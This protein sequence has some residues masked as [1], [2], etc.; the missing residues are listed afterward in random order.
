MPFCA[1]C[2][3][4]VEGRFCAKCGGAVAGDAGATGSRP[5]AAGGMTDNVASALCYV[6]TFIT[7]IVFLVL[8]PYNKNKTVRFHAFQ[9]IFMGAGILVF[10]IACSLIFGILHLGLFGALLFPLIGL[11]F[12]ILWIYM[13]ISAYQGKKVVLPLIGPLAEQQ[14]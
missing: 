1:T 12:F 3:A 5:A 2:G 13:I 9:A 10:D 8:E 14:A 6:L 11:G 7:G 4:P